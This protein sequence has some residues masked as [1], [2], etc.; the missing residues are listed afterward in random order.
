MEVQA[1]EIQLFVPGRIK[2]PASTLRPER[3]V[4]V[5]QVNG[6]FSGDNSRSPFW[7]R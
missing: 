6:S 3:I 1:D 4:G 7:P 2:I 5:G